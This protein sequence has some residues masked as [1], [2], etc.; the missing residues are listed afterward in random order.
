MVTSA[1][2][3]PAGAVPG[4]GD[5]TAG[6]DTGGTGLTDLFGG[7]ISPFGGGG[8]S[9]P[10]GLGGSSFDFG[11]AFDMAMDPTGSLGATQALGAGDQTTG[12]GD[13]SATSP[14]QIPGPGYQPGQVQ[15][16]NLPPPQQTVQAAQEALAPANFGFGGQPTVQGPTGFDT[17]A[18]RFNA[19]QQPQFNPALSA[20]PTQTPGGMNVFN[21]TY[22]TGTQ[23]VGQTPTTALDPRYAPGTQTLA[24]RMAPPVPADMAPQIAANQ[25]TTAGSVA[26]YETVAPTQQPATPINLPAATPTAGGT[27]APSTAPSGGD[28]APTT[29]DQGGAGPGYGGQGGAQ[30]GLQRIISDII[31][32]IGGGPGAFQRLL[33]DI[34]QQIQQQGGQGGGLY[35]NA[36]TDPS[37]YGALVPGWAQDPQTGQYYRTDG[38]AGGGTAGQDIR[39]DPSQDPYRNRP[40]APGWSYDPRT[41]DYRRT[42]GQ[43]PGG[44]AA[45]PGGPATDQ[46]RTV[47]TVPATADRPTGAGGTSQLPAPT[48]GT[49][50]SLAGDPTG[51]RTIGT[52]PIPPN[53]QMAAATGGDATSGPGGRNPIAS[54]I[55][56]PRGA[57]R[58]SGIPTQANVDRSVFQREAA[59]D[60]PSLPGAHSLIEQAAWMVNGEVE[61]NASVQVQRVQLETAFNRAQSRRQSLA[62]ALLPSLR[63]GDAG[64]YDGLRG[65]YAGTYRMRAR[66]T[67][68]QLMRFKTQVWDPVMAGSNLSDVGWGPMTGNA[69]AG[70]AARQFRR[71]TLGYKLPGGDTYFREAIPRGYRFPT[72]GSM[73]A[74]Q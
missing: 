12:A 7:G 22:A 45:A 17:V 58:P 72:I 49:P 46:P 31:G 9:D 55:Q 5:G 39:V 57:A 54:S 71:G 36:L 69:S 62:H 74:Y 73:V 19:M 40:L 21:P 41:G 38:Q 25:P 35:G 4:S 33:Q 30:A 37:Q 32:M 48:P 63:R 56:V 26:D 53:A 44:P 66:P 52:Q 11:S 51:A 42:G 3:N 47:R 13:T 68:A 20:I 10:F 70:V 24:A 28:G 65:M 16:Q 67:P 8:T 59:G 43:Q 27:G 23:A 60:R 34:M 50:G 14:D 29:P 15:Q 2:A 61:P 6:V 64:Y 18:S 1:A